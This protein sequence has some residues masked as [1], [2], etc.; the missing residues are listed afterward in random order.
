MLCR[1]G[2]TSFSIVS[3]AGVPNKF[4]KCSYHCFFRPF[5]RGFPHNFPDASALRLI[6]VLT[7][8]EALL[9]STTL[10]ALSTSPIWYL[11]GCYS[12]F[13]Y[14]ASVNHFWLLFLWLLPGSFRLVDV[15]FSC[16]YFV[17]LLWVDYSCIVR[18]SNR[19]SFLI[20]SGSV[21]AAS[22][23]ASTNVLYWSADRCDSVNEVLS[24]L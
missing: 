21:A 9:G 11:I 7:I 24:T 13:L 8:F 17:S 22:F 18:V 10:N 3:S 12:R 4:L 19:A 2:W 14:T 6:I 23:L 20:T 5:F 16:Q 1:T 15:K